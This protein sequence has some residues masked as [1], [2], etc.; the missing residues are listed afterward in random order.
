[1]DSIRRHIVGAAFAAAGLFLSAIQSG[2]QPVDPKPLRLETKIPLGEVRGR[3]DHMAHPDRSRSS[4]SLLRAVAGS[5][6]SRGTR[7]LFGTR[8]HMGVPCAAMR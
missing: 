2:A 5:L 1:M 8:V 6:L 4:Y 3:I 7:D